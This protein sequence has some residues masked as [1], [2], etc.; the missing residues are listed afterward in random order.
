MHFSTPI[1]IAA[2][3]QVASAAQGTVLI[4]D[5][6]D[7]SVQTFGYS[8]A[9]AKVSGSFWDTISKTANTTLSVPVDGY[10]VTSAFKDQKLDG[11]KLNLYVQ[12]NI[13]AG[14]GIV[15]GAAIQLVSPDSQKT[16]AMG[17][18]DICAYVFRTPNSKGAATDKGSCSA[19]ASNDC[20]QNRL[21]AFLA[22]PKC[23]SFATTDDGKCLPMTKDTVG[24]YQRKSSTSLLPCFLFLSILDFPSFIHNKGH[25]TLDT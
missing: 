7:F 13:P 22:D 1:V 18:W 15:A 8:G 24:T 16:D 6:S 19:L 9:N 12:D 2:A 21:K 17:D 3:A 23:G 11:W 4:S 5:S 20:V 25:V 14:S 10:S